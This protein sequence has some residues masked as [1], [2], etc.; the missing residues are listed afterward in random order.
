MGF[1]MTDYTILI[2]KGEKYASIIV[3][4]EH[5]AASTP[6]QFGGLILEQLKRLEDAQEPT[7]HISHARRFLE[8]QASLGLED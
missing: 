3:S 8:E 1:K 4:E 5:V 7:T 6:S 2:A